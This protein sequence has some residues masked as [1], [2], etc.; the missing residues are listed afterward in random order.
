M[1]DAATGVRARRSKVAGTPGFQDR[2]V[3][4]SLPR[5]I[6][7]V[8]DC[9]MISGGAGVGPTTV[10]LLEYF[11]ADRAY[12]TARQKLDAATRSVRVQEGKVGQLAAEHADAHK[13][14]VETEAKAK[15]LE[16]EVK[17]R[18]ER[19]ELLRG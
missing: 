8:A 14:A 11:R 1:R 9:Q 13:K 15:E 18:D 19:I 5:A 12:Q 10:A 16:L 2:T 7:G 6:L 3:S 17:S 4:T